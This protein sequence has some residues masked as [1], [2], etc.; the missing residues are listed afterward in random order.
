[1]SRAQSRRCSAAAPSHGHAARPEPGPL[2][3]GRS[4]AAGIGTVLELRTKGLGFV[5]FKFLSG[6]G[7][8]WLRVA[9]RRAAAMRLPRLRAGPQCL[10]SPMAPLCHRRVT[11]WNLTRRQFRVAG[12]A[13]VTV[14]VW[15]LLSTETGPGR[16]T[17]SVRSYLDLT[18][19]HA[20]HWHHPGESP[21]LA[22]HAGPTVSPARGLGRP[23]RFEVSFQSLFWKL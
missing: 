20:P 9:R 7:G 14:T 8:L 23:M 15:S 16:V 12:G 19:P 18:V 11:G 13:M 2:P 3:A 17:Y 1:M 21:N 22:S 4:R 5:H 10:E 6:R